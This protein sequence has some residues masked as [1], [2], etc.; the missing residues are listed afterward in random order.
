MRRTLWGRST[1]SNVMKVIWAL[2][3]M[4]L[5]YE[6]LDVARPTRPNTSL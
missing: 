6:R 3:T 2:E 1:S 4:K 5:P